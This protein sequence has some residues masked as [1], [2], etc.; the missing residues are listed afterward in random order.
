MFGDKLVETLIRRKPTWNT[1]LVF[2]DK[3][4]HLTQISFWD[5][6]GVVASPLCDSYRQAVTKAGVVD[7]VCVP[8]N[9]P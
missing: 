2:T 1:Y 7:A 9:A 8:G 3:D 4:Q 6:P 5:L